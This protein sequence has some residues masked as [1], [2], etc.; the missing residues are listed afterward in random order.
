MTQA[1]DT[2]RLDRAVDSRNDH[3]LGPDDGDITLVEYGSYACP[4]CRAA[5][6]EVAKLRD[7]FGD[8]LRYVFRQRPLTGSDLARRAADVAESA[9]DETAFWRSHVDLMTRSATLTDDDVDT[10]AAKLQAAPA[11]VQQDALARGQARVDAD[12]ASAKASG[13]R[14][15]PT[16]FINGRR[17]DGPWDEVSLGEAMLGSLGHRV[18]SAAVDFASWAP[19]TG[20]LLLLMSIVAIVVVNSPLGA[21]FSAF[22][23]TPFGFEFADA[24]FRMSLRHWVNDALLTI[25]FLLVGLEIKR[26]FTVGRL[27]QARSAAFP[28][29]AAIGGMAVPAALYSLVVPSGQWSH[30][31]GVPMATD[32]AFAVALIV[33]LGKRVPVELRIFLTAASIVDDIGA[34]IVVALF[35]SGAL[36]WDYLAGAA[37]ITVLLALL[38]RWGVYR[39]LPYAFLGIALWACIHAGGLH[40]TLAG[41]VLALFIPTR[42]PPNLKA[43]MAQATAVLTAETARGP[44]VLRHGPSTPA[45]RALDAIHD[46][47][48]SPADRTLR[49]IEPWSSYLVLPLFALANAGVALSTGM[50]AGREMLVS[51]IALGLVVGKPAGFMIVPALAVWAG[52]AIKPAAYSWRQL[53]GAGA[54]AGIGFTMSLFI[55]GQAFA[56]PDD[57]SAAKIAVFLA[58]IVSAV[59]GVALLWQPLRAE[60]PEDEAIGESAAAYGHSELDAGA[61]ARVGASATE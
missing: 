31:W 15:T 53:L 49:A 34:I 42:P 25:F 8:R 48:E 43:L 19:S 23:E 37:A 58:S 46:R 21:E 56:S 2:R 51:A 52:I 5:N 33:M 22:W 20:V 44:D 26:E 36:H 57:F 29:A 3:V 61:P 18:H 17:Y 39:A 1:T 24:R 11:A 4:Y 16:F 27:A 50:F 40:S 41:V 54:L 14:V 59:A 7:R 12:I 30:G 38:N 60:A 28:V 13:V 10:V 47:L 9:A 45:L 6:D 32:T 35:Y 55:A